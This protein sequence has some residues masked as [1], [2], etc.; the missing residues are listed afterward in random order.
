MMGNRLTQPNQSQLTALHNRIAEHPIYS[1]LRTVKDLRVFMEHHVY[2]VWDFMSLVKSLQRLLVPSRVPWL[3]PKD[4]VAARFINQMVLEEE[5]DQAFSGSTGVTHTSHFQGYCDAMIEVGANTGPIMRFLERI[6]RHGSY[7]A[8]DRCQVPLPAAQFMDFTF[9]MI[10]RGK[11]HELAAV[12]AHGRESLVPGMFLGM[13]EKA[14]IG[15]EKSPLLHRYL[16]RHVELDGNDHAPLALNLVE[17]LCQ[18][19]SN[20]EVEATDAAIQALQV[21]LEF[22]DGIHQAMTENR[23]HPLTNDIRHTSGTDCQQIIC[24]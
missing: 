7:G 12:L 16:H 1:S 24:N 13:I 18:G 2:A 22:W 17:N 10:A 15:T 20:K 3:P 8:V 6:L 19:D 4:P 5:S 14:H 21:R 23:R 11:P 9:S